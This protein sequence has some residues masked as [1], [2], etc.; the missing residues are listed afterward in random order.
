MKNKNITFTTLLIVFLL[1]TTTLHVQAFSNSLKNFVTNGKKVQIEL[2]NEQSTVRFYTGTN[3]EISNLDKT[4]RTFLT[5]NKEYIIEPDENGQPR[6]FIQVF[7]TEE[8]GKAEKIKEDIKRDFN[9]YE[10]RIKLV[11]GLYKVE[12]GSF[13]Q[14]AAA[15]KVSKNLNDA[16][17]QTWVKEDEIKERTSQLVVKDTKGNILFK[18]GTIFCEGVIRLK[19]NL[20]NGKMQFKLN[21][22]KIEVLN[23]ID[24]LTLEYGLLLEN[25]PDTNNLTFLKAA[26]VLNRSRALS[27][28]L[29]ETSPYK[30]PQ[31]KGISGLSEI[32][33]VA[34]DNTTAKVI[35]KDGSPYYENID[36]KNLDRNHNNVES[37]LFSKLDSIE[38][39]DLDTTLEEKQIVDANIDIGLKYKEIRQLTWSGPR[40][41]SIVDLNTLKGRH[42]VTSFIS[43][44]KIDGLAPLSEVVSKNNALVGVN[45][46]FYTSSGTP[47]GLVMIDG[48]MVTEPLYN[49]A[50]LGIT[51]S[52]EILIDNV[53]WKGLLKTK[54]NSNIIIDAVNRKPN[55]DNEIILY[56]R[57]FGK[58]TP[59]FNQFSTEIVVEENRIVRVDK[60]ELIQNEI[61]EEGF[62]IKS[63]NSNPEEYS[64]FEPGKKIEY[65][66][67]FSP[68]WHEEEIVNIMGGG[69]KLITKGEV[70]VTGQAENFQSDII[71]GRAPR[72]A[73]GL[74]EDDHLLFVMVDGR[75]PELS[76][77]ITLKN[78]AHYLQRLDVKEA[79]N[80]DG[81]DSS[82]LVIRGYTFNNP[83]GY[84]EIGS[85]ILIKKLQ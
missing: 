8:K 84:R 68:N 47:L 12:V 49:R 58:K 54:N 53:N 50:A 70:T 76:V 29:N 42:K 80:L 56:N 71:K 44:N 21:D 1:L 74:T 62:I 36:F 35:Y 24:F 77:G 5:K 10:V 26:A 22:K 46:G 14:E 57:F 39:I 85:G 18:N 2:Y 23:E 28:I 37:V 25:Q 59:Q 79:M 7:A 78:L 40:V 38:I 16:G 4:K 19:D 11:D 73:V 20:Y 55:N 65:K 43:N 9:G 27:K 30:F 63:F 6:W 75:Q 83:S 13:N 45:G 72:T 34:V 52:G 15:E 41:I 67:I 61:P 31:Y 64:S 32:I 51:K 82:Q 33:R 66:N 81:G 3:V 17:W 60:G 48:K 69:P